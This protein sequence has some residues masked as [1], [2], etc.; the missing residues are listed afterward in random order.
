MIDRAAARFAATLGVVK[1]GEGC[2]RR[3]SWVGSRGGKGEERGTGKR[4]GQVQ[5]GFSQRNLYVRP[6]FVR[7]Y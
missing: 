7:D 3:V 2:R 4:G 1:A 6:L 5:V